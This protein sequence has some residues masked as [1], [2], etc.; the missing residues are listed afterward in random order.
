LFIKS[1]GKKLKKSAEW[2]VDLLI[3]SKNIIKFINNNTNKLKIE[4]N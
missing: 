4:I 1:A 2:Y 3:I